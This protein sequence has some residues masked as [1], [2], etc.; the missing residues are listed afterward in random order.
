M[1]VTIR[2]EWLENYFGRIEGAD[3]W[4]DLHDTLGHWERQLYLALFRD[5][6]A[7]H[8]F[9]VFT[10][11]PAAMTIR[12]GA[13]QGVSGSKPVYQTGTVDVELDTAD[14][15]TLLGPTA[16]LLAGNQRYLVVTAE[17]VDVAYDA[18]IDD[19]GGAGFYSHD[20]GIRYR[21]FMGAEALAGA[22]VLPLADL[23]AA[24]T[25][26]KSIPIFNYLLD[27]GEVAS[28]ITHLT[29]MQR[30]W[31]GND[32]GRALQGAVGCL[33][34]M[35]VAQLRRCY[36]S[37]T[38]MDEDTSRMPLLTPAAG[39]AGGSVTLTGD[40]LFLFGGGRLRV[41]DSSLEQW[42]S[43]SLD[44]S[45]TYFIRA[46]IGDHQELL[47]YA[48]KG[49]LPAAPGA[50][51]TYPV[52]LKGTPGG[53]AGGAFPSTEVDI[54]IGKVVTGLAGAVP[55]VTE[56]RQGAVFYET[57]IAAHN[58]VGLAPTTSV[59]YNLPTPHAC[60]MEIFIV[61]RQAGVLPA[62]ADVTYVTGY[63]V[64]RTVQYYNFEGGQ[65]YGLGQWLKEEAAP[66]RLTKPAAADGVFRPG[67]RV[68]V[69]SK[70]RSV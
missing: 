22:A 10:S 70:V 17:Y 43:G 20:H 39:G 35:G 58:P 57:T 38:D 24:Y 23:A 2:S 30:Y 15:G 42:S 32:V 25:A 64:L 66:T 46:Y 11:V 1:T 7:M 27:F 59:M 14:S 26:T 3:D 34:N 9:P 36:L 13:W 60:D 21:L 45:S 47:I 6:T 48:Q 31:L 16:V 63:P 37:G 19:N 68:I 41:Q 44:V 29:K 18:Y 67:M 4:E 33:G 52:G 8:T 56:Y 55:V 49:A 54:L 65:V 69:M 40:Y 50:G 51:Y 53:A 62:P 12:I 5:G 61:D 28:D